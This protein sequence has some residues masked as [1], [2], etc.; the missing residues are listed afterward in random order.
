MIIMDLNFPEGINEG[1][2][3]ALPA[4]ALAKAGFQ[5]FRVSGFQ[6][7]RVSGFAD[8]NLL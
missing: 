5:G 1:S 7:F 2:F 3:Q 8:R 6:S 4:E